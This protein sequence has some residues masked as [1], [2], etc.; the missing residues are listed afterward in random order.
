MNDRFRVIE[1]LKDRYRIPATVARCTLVC[2]ESGLTGKDLREY[3][4]ILVV[5]ELGPTY[6]EARRWYAGRGHKWGNVSDRD[7]EG[8]LVDQ[9]LAGA[10]AVREPSN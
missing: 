2:R 6:E 8:M 5:E 7:V 4:R 1:Q 9:V 3:A 10:T